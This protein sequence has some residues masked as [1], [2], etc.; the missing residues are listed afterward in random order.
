MIE[1]LIFFC[2]F[3]G[4]EIVLSKEHYQMLSEKMNELHISVDTKEFKY[5]STDV[6]IKSE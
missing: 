5:P 6:I 2:K 3:G 1:Q 4:K